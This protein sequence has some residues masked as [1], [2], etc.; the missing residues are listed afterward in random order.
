[1]SRPEL[2]DRLGIAGDERLRY[3]KAGGGDQLELIGLG[4]V[5]RLGDRAI[6]DER[7]RDLDPGGELI[8]QR[9]DRYPLGRVGREMLDLG[10]EPVVHDPQIDGADLVERQAA[11]R[12]GQ[13]A[14]NAATGDLESERGLE[15]TTLVEPTAIGA[16]PV[17]LGSHEREGRL[18][19]NAA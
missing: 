15:H 3:R 13:L 12:I 9:A 7:R 18:R 17:E 14:G 2:D 6:D 8:V 16:Q 11:V 1:M 10:Q 5:A 4:R 19:P